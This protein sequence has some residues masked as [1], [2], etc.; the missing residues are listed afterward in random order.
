MAQIRTEKLVILRGVKY[1]LMG[2]KKV[3]LGTSALRDVVITK[4]GYFVRFF[5]RARIGR[6]SC[7]GMFDSYM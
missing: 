6:G 5:L 4:F 1:K 7:T 2:E 3:F